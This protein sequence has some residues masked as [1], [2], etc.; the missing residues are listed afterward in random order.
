M[1]GRSSTQRLLPRPLSPSRFRKAAAFSSSTLRAYS[2]QPPTGSNNAVK[3]W[4]FLVI[5]GLGTAGYAMLIKSRAESRW[6]RAG[7]EKYLGSVD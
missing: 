1:A 3:F 5:I 6:E 4:P 7:K 2:S